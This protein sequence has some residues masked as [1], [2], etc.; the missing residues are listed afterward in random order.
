MLQPIRPHGLE[1]L[2]VYE[3]I[4]L[5][6]EAQFVVAPHGAGLTNL[7]Y[8]RPGCFVLELQM[9]AYVNWAFRRFCA[10]RGLTYDCLVGRSVG[11]WTELDPSVHGMEWLISVP[12]VVAAVSSIINENSLSV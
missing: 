4:C 8:A 5:F 12:H 11:K 2:S 9:D 1:S 10:L 3:Q 6:R 7:A